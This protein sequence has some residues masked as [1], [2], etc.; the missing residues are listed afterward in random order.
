MIFFEWLN[1]FFDNTPDPKE[2]NYLGGGTSKTQL[3]KMTKLQLE[4][5]GRDEG[6]ELDRRLT[7]TK[8]VD[9]LHNHLLKS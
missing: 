4:S 6:I 7:K 5:M 8:L 3:A 2:V 9:Q 1:K